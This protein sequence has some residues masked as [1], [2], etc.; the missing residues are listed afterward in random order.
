MPEKKQRYEMI[1][2]EE[3]RA[4]V[5]EIGRRM[6][7]ELR[8]PSELSMADTIR[9]AIRSHP[10]NGTRPGAWLEDELE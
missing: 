1:L 8:W 9:Y 5:R 6:K 3:D 7:I 10:W 4:L 2:E